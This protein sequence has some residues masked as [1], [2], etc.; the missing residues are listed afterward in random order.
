MQPGVITQLQLTRLDSR[1]F[2][3]IFWSCGEKTL[4]E[5]SLFGKSGIP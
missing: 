5:T 4:V 1:I 2:R 3:E